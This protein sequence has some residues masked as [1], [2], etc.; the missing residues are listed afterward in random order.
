MY[1]APKHKSDLLSG[2]SLTYVQK[3]RFVLFYAQK[4]LQLLFNKL[5]SVSYVSVLVVDHEFRHNIVKVG[6]DSEAIA[7]WI[8]RIL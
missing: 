8:H 2:E 5:M 1:H 6:V 4:T 3:K 7:E